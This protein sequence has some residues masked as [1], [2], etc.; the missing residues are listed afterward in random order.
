LPADE[1][2]HGKLAGEIPFFTFGPDN[3][4]EGVAAT[5]VVYTH[6]IENAGNV[7]DV[8]LL[9]WTDSQEWATVTWE[10]SSLTL[11]PG[12]T[13]VVTV[14]VNIPEGNVL[15]LTDRAVVT[16]T[17]TVN[18][19]LFAAVVDMTQVPTRRIYLPLIMRGY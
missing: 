2:P 3:S 17:S 18:S 5:Q 10:P 4:G 8:Y 1:G 16:A 15:G 9:A 11:S 14:T 6:T 12:E 19:A 7:S 13:A